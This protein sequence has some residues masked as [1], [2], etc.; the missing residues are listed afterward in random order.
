MSDTT[1]SSQALAK[2]QLR[3]A[4]SKA[5]RKMDKSGLAS[6]PKTSK[7]IQ[8]NPMV[9]LFLNIYIHI[10]WCVHISPHDWPSLSPEKIAGSY[11]LDNSCSSHSSFLFHFRAFCS[12]KTVECHN[13]VTCVT[14]MICRMVLSGYDQVVGRSTVSMSLGETQKR[15]PQATVSRFEMTV[16][17]KQKNMHIL[18]IDGISIFMYLI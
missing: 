10:S 13:G 17:N 14:W 5:I 11:T 18:C 4:F 3:S 8:A 7:H 2:I 15:W 12:M 9:E 16:S 1:E 6:T